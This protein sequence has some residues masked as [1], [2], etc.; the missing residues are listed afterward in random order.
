[1]SRRC[2]NE[3]RE[4]VTRK[5]EPEWRLDSGELEKFQLQLTRNLRRPRPTLSLHS[6]I[7]ALLRRR[8]SNCRVLSRQALT[9]PRQ[10][11]QQELQA[12][13]ITQKSET[14]RQNPKEN[15]TTDKASDEHKSQKVAE[16]DTTNKVVF[17]QG[18]IWRLD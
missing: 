9:N 17:F 13:R 18:H 5:L 16:I 3:D 7:V 4:R 2:E 15:D 8:N 12:H 1:V 14:T 11:W 6:R 10:R